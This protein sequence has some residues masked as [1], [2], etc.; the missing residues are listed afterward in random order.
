MEKEI[1]L[2]I[3]P[4]RKGKIPTENGMGIIHEAECQMEQNGIKVNYLFGVVW[5]LR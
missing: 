2:L 3:M 5:E 1:N 4:K